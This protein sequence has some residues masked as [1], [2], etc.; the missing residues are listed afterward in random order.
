MIRLLAV[1]VLSGAVATSVAAQEPPPIEAGIDSPAARYFED[2]V[3]VTHYAIE[4]ALPR[5]EGWIQGRVGIDFTVEAPIDRIVFDF[6]GLPIDEVTLDGVAAD[7]WS[8]DNGLLSIP[9]GSGA[10]GSAHTV[11]VGYHGV[12]DD[13]LILG[14]TV[15]GQ[16]SAFVDNWPNR[17]RFWVPS[18][19]HPSDKATA[20]FTVH[21]PA[22]WAVI[23]NGSLVAPPTAT[24]ADVPGPDV[25]ARRSWE[26]ATEVPHP[27]YTLVVGGAEMTIDT[28]GLA[29]CGSAPAS[30][31]PDGCIAVTTW[32]F[33]ESV[34]A[35]AP[36]FRRAADMVDFFTNLIGPFPYEKLANV[37]SATR[38]GGMENS[39]AIFY[40][41]QALAAGRDIEG[42]VSHEI[43]HQW[44]GDSVTEA[45]WGHLW[46]SEGFATYFGAL[47]FEEV[48]G[49]DALRE[50]M[51]DA[52]A[53]YLASG[54]TARPVVDDRDDLFSLLNRNSYQKGALVLHML[55][56]AVGDEA[57]FRGI[58]EYYA[59]HR[60]QTAL[61]SDLLAVMEEVTGSDLAGFFEQWLERPGYPVIE[62][63][64]NPIAAGLEVG[65]QQVQGSDAPR[66]E[67]S[68]DIQVEWDGGTVRQTV[69]LDGSGTTLTI[70]GAPADARIVLD[71][72]GWLLHRRVDAR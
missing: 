50:R 34:E 59:R 31:R 54:D 12:P 48:D 2:G 63:S 1:A 56:R 60:D 13:G 19:D 10:A 52:A 67:L 70:D 46:L 26:Y 18:V 71:P 69:A 33:P 66:F 47:F 25:G 55:R 15:H 36:S 45:E 72:D 44:F 57:F 23:A 4:V 11:S 39:S 9:L 53:A 49:P 16:P 21:A 8:H 51:A 42:T 5:E 35:A 6:T 37:Q 40:S 41:Q 7:G 62:V 28:V 58:R 29:A 64:A 17:T 68:V 27:S 3:D 14:Q 61:T 43:A 65:L 22:E 30:A 20:R 24:P 38:F 32:L